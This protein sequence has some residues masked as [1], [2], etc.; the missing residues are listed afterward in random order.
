MRYIII[1][2]VTLLFASSVFAQTPRPATTCVVDHVVSGDTVACEAK[3]G[4]RA[5][6]KRYEFRIVG[7]DAPELG[8]M[9]NRWPD[10][11]Y[12]EE[13]TD[14][15][16]EMVLN[17]PVTL[18]LRGWNPTTAQYSARIYATVKGRKQDVGLVQV[19]NGWAWNYAYAARTLTANEKAIYAQAQ[20]EAKF[21]KRGL[22]G[23][24]AKPIPPSE[25]RKRG[26]NK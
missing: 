2:A 18:E 5:K 15:L 19:M 25:W 3:I 7:V 6:P 21:N 14:A 16:A 10:Q 4:K 26:N 8:D 11:P 1:I 9:R 13:A 22:W 23:G 20:G 17:K 24:T 12:W